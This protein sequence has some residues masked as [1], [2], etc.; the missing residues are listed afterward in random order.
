MNVSRTGQFAASATPSI[1]EPIADR[2]QRHV[3]SPPGWPLLALHPPPRSPSILPGDESLCSTALLM[4]FMVE[5]S[6][7]E[8]RDER[9]S[10]FPFWAVTARQRIATESVG[11]HR[12]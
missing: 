7:C 12:H 5:C 8:S 11:G 9:L 4:P 6:A 10:R 3:N 1:G 2:W